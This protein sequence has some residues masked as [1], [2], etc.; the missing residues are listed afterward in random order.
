[1]NEFIRIAIASR[2]FTL[3]AVV[4][5]AIT[6]GHASILTVT[7]VVVAFASI[8]S[9]VS[10]VAAAPTHWVIAVEGTLVAGVVVTA[11]PGSAVFLPYLVVLPLL[12]GLARGIRGASLVIA[13]QITVILGVTV[14]LGSGMSDLRERIEPLAPW[15]LTIV[16]AGLLGAWAKKLGKSPAGTTTDENYDSARRLLGQLRPLA[17]RL[18]TGLDP[19]TIASQILAMAEAA[20]QQ[21][22]SALVTRTDGGV[23]VPLA[24]RGAG[25]RDALDPADELVTMAW[26]TGTPASKLLKT[27]MSSELA[28]VALPLRLGAETVAVLIIH[29]RADFL[30]APLKALHD[31]LQEMSLR[32]A[33]AM[34]FDDVRTLVTADER[35]RLAREIH[36]GVAQEVASLGYLIDELVATADQPRVVAGLHELRGTLSRIV[37]ELR[38]SIFDLRSDVGNSGGL[39]SALSDYVRTVGARSSMK[40]HLSLDE[41]ATRRL[42]PGVETELFRIVQEAITNARKHARAENLWVDCRLQPPLAVI[43]VRDDGPGLGRPRADSYGLRIMRERAERIGASLVVEDFKQAEDIVGTSVT[44]S[45]GESNLVVND[46]MRAAS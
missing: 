13:C 21:G 24:Y 31:E 34:A 22:P 2:A 1:V 17:R 7:G 33:T 6:F 19:V 46:G 41:S 39:G 44:V 18:P 26:A 35:Q 42:S 12:T 15:A 3:A 27:D 5:L 28:L 9:Y 37:T 38:L 45:L 20:T 40:V 29:T 36:D 8:A 25:A 16:G 14:T 30:A 11:L 43:R 23:F 10:A 32:L 4:G